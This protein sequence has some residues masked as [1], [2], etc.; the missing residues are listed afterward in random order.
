MKE[1]HQT[2]HQDTIHYHLAGAGSR[3]E[4]E[5]EELVIMVLEGGGS[6]QSARA[7]LDARREKLGLTLTAARQIE[8]VCSE[9]FGRQQAPGTGDGAHPSGPQSREPREPQRLPRQQSEPLR[10]GAVHRPTCD[11][12]FECPKCGQQLQVSG[13]QAGSVLTCP[14]CNEV[15]IVVPGVP[16]AQ[17]WGIPTECCDL[18]WEQE[19]CAQRLDLPAA[20]RDFFGQ[21]FLLIPNGEFTYGGVN[22]HPECQRTIQSPFYLGRFPVTVEQWARFLAVDRYAWEKDWSR[23]TSSNCPCTNVTWDDAQ[24]YC[25]WLSRESGLVYRLPTEEE[26]EKAARGTDGRRYPWG[27]AEASSRY[28]HAGLKSATAPVGSYPAGRSPYGCHDMA[29]NAWEWCEDWFD[30]KRLRRVLRGGNCASAYL[31]VTLL[32]SSREG[33]APEKRDSLVGFRCV[34]EVPRS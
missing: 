28:A 21:E 15:D 7:R 14:G 8:R 20:V 26:W 2:T 5:Y 17:F 13:S 22:G 11:V 9:E 32:S 24:A 34:L 27:N 16:G 3:A 1:F 10:K 25:R 4:V 19:A 18:L 29:G 33:F 30:H 31:V 6:L 23:A 12:L